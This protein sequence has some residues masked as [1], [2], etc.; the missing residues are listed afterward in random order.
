[1]TTLHSSRVPPPAFDDL[2]ECMNRI[3][4]PPIDGSLVTETI[5]PA[6]LALREQFTDQH[7]RTLKDIA[8]MRQAW[9]CLAMVASLGPSDALAL[10]GATDSY[11]VPPIL[12]SPTAATAA[13]NAAAPH[14][15]QQMQQAYKHVDSVKAKLH[16][17]K[18]QPLM[19]MLQR[20]PVAS[21]LGAATFQ[22]SAS[23][24]ASDDSLRAFACLDE[25]ALK[26]IV[27][28]C[29]LQLIEELSA[30]TQELRRAYDAMDA[31]AKSKADTGASKFS[32][33]TLIVGSVRDFHSSLLG[34]LG[35]GPSLDFLKAIQ[36]E[37]CE[38]PDSN[39][40]FTSSNYNL[41]TTPALEWSYAVD[42]VQPPE[43][44]LS[45]GRVRRKI[46]SIDKLMQLDIVKKAGL[47]RAEVICVSLYTGPMFI[48]YN[49][50]L[51]QGYG[52]GGNMFATTIF[53]LVSAV[54]KIA[55]VTE[56]S[57]QLTLYCGL[58]SV[59][60]L[61]ES[62]GHPDAFGSKGWTEFGFRS[63]TADKAI[64]LDYSGIKKGNPHPMIM[65]IK[66]NA[67]DRGACIADLSQ[68]QSEQEYL[69][70][71]C[72]FLQP[73][74]PPSL[75]VVAEGI[76][77]VI[78]VHLSLNLKTETMEELVSKKKRMHLDSARLL[79]DEVK[80]ELERL[81]TSAESLERKKKDPYA[82]YDD[83][84]LEAFS[85]SINAQCDAIVER[86]NGIGVADYVND[87]TFRG[88]VSEILNMKSWAKEKWQL[89][90]KDESKYIFYVKGFSLS[91][92]HRMWLSHLRKHI[93][94]AAT[95]SDERQLACLQ[96][97]QSKGLVKAA[98]HGEPNA[99]GEDLI[100]AAGADGW[101]ADDINA[102]L[103]AGADVATADANGKTGVWS[104]A[105][106]GHLSTLKALLGAGG[107]VTACTNASEENKKLDLIGVF[108]LHMAAWNG[109]VDCI[110]ELIASKAN[111]LQ[112]SK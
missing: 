21:V 74:G 58:G 94:E 110:E 80:G 15:A 84:A 76:V 79:A 70:V 47:Q 29:S 64:A 23:V 97:L 61:P 107:D 85:A 13:R 99:E 14:R 72:S 109:H 55:R 52:K 31:S 83:D 59:S 16:D 32:G 63:T 3:L 5:L 88:L 62:F 86:H 77:N 92:C 65:A 112:R 46:R 105:S 20:L 49:P 34:R 87:N 2:L 96:L 95:G 24:S 66:P 17:L 78:P 57:E 111:V 90:L 36:L 56:I 28:T 4:L 41:R 12:S 68:Y 37:H 53:V 44:Q 38:R 102:L 30:Q 51:R 89:W 42:G 75:E 7:A 91:A 82:A 35:Q 8:S 18:H 50:C 39:Q 106:S 54:Q 103:G 69:F 60:D 27:E 6:F 19:N 71:P 67:I 45:H 22:T 1:M 9:S 73:N 101:G 108:P 98:A 100:V 104:A 93:R 11:V 40:E 33:T 48:K 26:L 25:P 43:A 81:A 10:P